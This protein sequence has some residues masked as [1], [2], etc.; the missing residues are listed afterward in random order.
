MPL[1]GYLVGGFGIEKGQ[2]SFHTPGIRTLNRS[3]G[4]N[5]AAR[6]SNSRKYHNIFCAVCQLEEYC[7]S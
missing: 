4:N 2:F 3:R 5:G 7:S 6:L 1:A